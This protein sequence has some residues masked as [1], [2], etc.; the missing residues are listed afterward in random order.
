MGMVCISTV[1]IP[2]VCTVLRWISW[3]YGSDMAMASP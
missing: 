1:R 2:V 3:S